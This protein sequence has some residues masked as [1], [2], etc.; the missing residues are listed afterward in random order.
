MCGTLL[1]RMRHGSNSWN[2]R[3]IETSSAQGFSFFVLPVTGGL[4]EVFLF[5]YGASH[6]RA[7]EQK[8]VRSL[9]VLSVITSSRTLVEGQGVGR[10]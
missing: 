10:D 6:R 2:I 9:R 7:R 1:V 8:D 4:P 3:V 5:R